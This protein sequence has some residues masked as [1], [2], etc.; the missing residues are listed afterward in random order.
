[1]EYGVIQK[2]SR[3]CLHATCS[4][5]E[6]VVARLYTVDRAFFFHTAPGPQDIPTTLTQAALGDILGVRIEAGWLV[7]LASKTRFMRLHEQFLCVVVSQWG[8]L[9][10][11]RS[12]CPSVAKQNPSWQWGSC[13]EGRKRLDISEY[14]SSDVEVSP[15]W[16]CKNNLKLLN[17][18]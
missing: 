14:P 2:R 11:F 9:T 3:C 17:Y 4:Y 5:K 12:R 10:A 1:M 16:A 18:Q 15:C 6:C 8:C 7:V 13:L